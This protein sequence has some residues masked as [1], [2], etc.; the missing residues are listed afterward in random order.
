MKSKTHSKLLPS[1]TFLAICCSAAHAGSIS[2]TFSFQQGDLRKDGVLHGGGTLYTGGLDGTIS[3][4]ASNIALTTATTATIGNQFQTGTTGNGRNFVGLFSY[5]LTELDTFIAANTSSASSVTVSSVAFK[6]VSTGGTGTGS[7]GAISLYQTDPFTSSAT[8]AT[9]NGSSAWSAPFQTGTGTFGF[10]GGGSALTGNL[11]TT[12]PSVSTASYV[13]NTALQWTSS[14]AF[15]S[16]VNTTLQGDKKLN[17]MAARPLANLDGRV[18]YNTGTAATVD[19]RP[20]LLVT[21]SINSFS[22]WTGAASDSWATAGN[23]TVAPATGDNVRFNSSSTANLATTL[24]QDF[25]LNSIAIVD[26]SGPISISGTNTLTL[27]AGG[28]DLSAATQDLS[29]AAPVALGAGQSWNIGSNRTLSVSSPITS[30]AGNLSITGAGKVSLSTSNILPNGAGSGNVAVI[31]TLDLNGTSQT[32]NAL[33]NAGVLDNTGSGPSV[34]TYGSNNTSGTFSGTIQNTSGTVALTKIGS[35]NLTL[36]GTNTF[37][38]GFTNNGTGDVLPQNS[39]AFGTGP[40]VM[41]GSEIYPTLGNYTYPNSLTLNGATLRIGGGNSRTVTWNGPVTATGA[42]GLNADGGTGGITLASTLDIT[43]ATFTSFANGTTNNI[44]GNISGTGGNIRVTLGTL[45]LSGDNSYTGTTTVSGT[46]IL[47]TLSTGRISNSSNIII[48]GASSWNIRSTGGWIY[49]GTISG[50]G[51]GSLLLNTSTNTE[52]AGNVS[53]V[54]SITTNDAG[55]NAKISGMISGSNFVQI[56]GGSS[57][58]LSGNNSYTGATNV[59]NGTLILGGAGALPDTSAVTLGNVNPTLQASVS[60][61]ESAGTL[62]V[63]SPATIQLG[64]DAALAFANS[65]GTWTGTLN[66][67][68]NFVSGSS[69]RFGTDGSGLST[70]QLAKISATGLGAFSINASGYLTAAAAGS[71][72]TTWAGAALFDDDANADG[73]KNGLAWILGA[74][75]PSANATSLVPAAGAPSGYL[76]LTFKRVNPY[77]PAKL[78]VEYSNNFGTWTKLEIPAAS[79]TIASSDVEVE[80]VPGTPDSVTVKIPTSHASGGKLFG[81]LSTTQN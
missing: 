58:T 65:N 17:L 15:I 3:D 34:L 72:Y 25:S 5:N 50:D 48:N 28:L 23:W 51:T 31:G 57:L 45:Q 75:S 67:T 80:V 69:I 19:N 4:N 56:S 63:T 52:V 16:A 8:W 40:V 68:G 27:G 29:I 49:N 20:E 70:E 42:S 37:S 79:G 32:V 33:T 38:G 10:T 54:A 64:T 6:L 43:G 76:T 11:G 81:R 7:T 41:N 60:G 36:S 24:D 59:V 13:A 39:A 30:L 55:T 46:A 71:P 21:L 53:G 66:I 9:T 12:S 61:T 22:Q 35:G 2:T 1:I 62:N 78:F 26:P 47:R 77:A 18:F 44:Q 73:V 14:A 74:A